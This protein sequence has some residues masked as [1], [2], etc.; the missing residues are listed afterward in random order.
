MEDDRHAHDVI[1]PT[2]DKAQQ[3]YYMIIVIMTYIDR[4]Q[5]YYMSSVFCYFYYY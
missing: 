3:L 5:I 2:D 4:F 1:F